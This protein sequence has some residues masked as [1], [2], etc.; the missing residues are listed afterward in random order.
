MNTKSLGFRLVG[1]YAGLLAAV[2]L[3]LAALML[4]FMR[5]Y[6]DASL[7]NTQARRARQIADTLVADIGKTGEAALGREVESLYSPEANDR[8]IRVTR[9]DG[10]VIYASGDPRNHAFAAARVPP[11]R[12]RR[13]DSN[14]APLM[15]SSERLRRVSLMVAR[16]SLRASYAKM[17]AECVT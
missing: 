6:L 10:S 16:C 17:E 11:Q 12:I 15:D 14:A 3:L 4:A 5:H 9:A 8:F 1:W 7:L 2:F 13:P